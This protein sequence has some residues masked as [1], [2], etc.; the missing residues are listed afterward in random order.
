MIWQHE[1]QNFL[2]LD[3]W[4]KEIVLISNRKYVNISNLIIEMLIN[5]NNKVF[6]CTFYDCAISSNDLHINF[7][8]S[9]FIND[10]HIKSYDLIIVVQPL[11]T[12]YSNELYTKMLQLEMNAKSLILLDWPNQFSYKNRYTD[13]C[14][15]YLNALSID[16]LKLKEINELIKMKLLNAKKF[17]LKDSNGTALYFARKGDVKEIF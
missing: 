11:L 9:I 7:E 14:K 13:V 17:F 15:L 1:V 12:E 10:K 4:D 6:D 2:C 8:E 5:K 3:I 16:Y